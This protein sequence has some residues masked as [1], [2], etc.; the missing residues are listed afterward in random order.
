MEKEKYKVVA[1]LTLY[2]KITYTIHKKV[3]VTFKN[4]PVFSYWIPT[5]WYHSSKALVQSK[6]EL[7]NEF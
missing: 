6:C 1:K 3:T 2:G 4:E 5:F 7:L